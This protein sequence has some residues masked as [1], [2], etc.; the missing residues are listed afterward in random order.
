MKNIFADKKGIL[1]LFKTNKLSEYVMVINSGDFK[2]A[3]VALLSVSTENCVATYPNEL[4]KTEIELADIIVNEA[5]K[6]KTHSTFMKV[7]GKVTPQVRKI[8][9]EDYRIG[10]IVN[11]Q[12][13]QGIS[14][15]TEM[16]YLNLIKDKFSVHVEEIEEK[17][18]VQKTRDFSSSLLYPPFKELVDTYKDLQEK[19]YDLLPVEEKVLK[20]IESGVD[21]FILLQGPPGTGK[22][23]TAHIWA[24]RLNMPYRES[25]G[26]F[27]NTDQL[28]GC[29]AVGLED[30]VE[31]VGFVP[32]GLLECY[33]HGGLYILNE[34]NYTRPDVM[35]VVQGMTDG[36]RV[37]HEKTSKRLVPRHDNFVLVMTINPKAKGS[38]PLNEALANRFTSVID[39]AKETDASFFKKL[40][41]IYPDTPENFLKALSKVPNIVENW[42]VSM[43][44]AGFCSIRQLSSFIEGIGNYETISREDFSEEFVLRVLTPVCSCNIFNLEKIRALSKSAD[45]VELTKHLYEAFNPKEIKRFSL[46][47][48]LVSVDVAKRKEDIE[49]ALKD[50]IS[51]SEKKD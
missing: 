14:D 36:T 33:E 45:Y 8:N 40:K 26:M 12:M 15:F 17:S 16:F 7:T 11:R 29:Y 22:T 49:N 10:K 35:S 24:I 1:A 28:V 50:F 48:V 39:Y 47:E 18:F 51:L 42:A 20:G 23:T 37:L 5:V 46:S 6:S 44:S 9:Y 30:G 13:E 41:K 27:D 19:N 31:T 4:S 3:V 21:R 32:G 2:K 34:A 38:L 43:N 25:T